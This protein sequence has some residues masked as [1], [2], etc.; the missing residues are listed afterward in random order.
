MQWSTFNICAMHFIQI[1]HF[2]KCLLRT[3]MLLLFTTQHNTHKHNLHTVHLAPT[4]HT[5]KVSEGLSLA[6]TIT[7][8][9]HHIVTFTYWSYK[10]LSKWKSWQIERYYWYQY[11]LSV[12]NIA[13]W[14]N[15]LNSVAFILLCWVRTFEG[16]VLRWWCQ[17]TDSNRKQ[18]Q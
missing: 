3:L 6:H 2:Q 4:A 8:W 16:R 12:F 10:I 11:S 5:N 17:E 9:Q 7:Y 13:C 18:G 15:Q 1:F 14:E